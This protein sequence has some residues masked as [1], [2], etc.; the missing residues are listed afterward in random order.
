LTSGTRVVEL[1]VID[2]GVAG[3]IKLLGLDVDGVVTNNAVYLGLVEGQQVEFKQF[4]IQDGLAMGLARRMGLVVAWVSGRY[5]DATTL[6]ATQL[7][8]DELV[9]DRGARKVPA[10]TEMLLRRGLGWEEVA[11]LG[12]D[13][14]D[15]PLLRRVGLPLAVANAVD[16]VKRLAAYT[17]RASGGSGAVREAIEVLLQ[18]QGR[19]DEAVRVYLEDRG[20]TADGR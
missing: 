9:Q 11:F 10:M 17:T 20:E 3:R 13:L 7:N 18:A 15:I 1:P 5:S 8:V 6:R 12:D 16:E 19:W 14:A 4:D 2:T